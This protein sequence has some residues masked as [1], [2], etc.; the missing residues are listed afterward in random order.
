MFLLLLAIQDIVM[1][2][3]STLYNAYYRSH[4]CKLIV[5]NN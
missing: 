2:R 5:I 1:G 3:P 4:L